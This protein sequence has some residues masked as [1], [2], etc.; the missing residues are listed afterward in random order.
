VR[1]AD[2]LHDQALELEDVY[3]AGT[4]QG[5]SGWTALKRDAGLLVAEPGP[6]ED[7]FSRRFGDLLHVDDPAAA[8]RDA[9]VGERNRRHPPTLD[10]K[11]PSSLGVQMLAYQIDGRHEQAAGPKPS[12]SA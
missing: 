6:E 9:A 7:Y 5:R 8:R 10:A 3:R 4:G 1:L 12:S 2:F 11:E